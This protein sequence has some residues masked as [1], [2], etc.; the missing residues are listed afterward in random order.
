MANTSPKTADA[1]NNCV[2]VVVIMCALKET[3][4]VLLV[5]MKFWC[6]GGIVKAWEDPR[7]RIVVTKCWNGDRGAVMVDD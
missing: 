1:R 6:L 4:V 7:R 3:E 2:V 5:E